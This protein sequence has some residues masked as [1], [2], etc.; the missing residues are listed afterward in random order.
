MHLTDQLSSEVP[1]I[2]T[3]SLIKLLEWLT[4]LREMV[5]L[6]DQITDLLEK[7]VTQEQ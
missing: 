4:E 7:A 1:T 5:Y 6:L 2:P 3:V